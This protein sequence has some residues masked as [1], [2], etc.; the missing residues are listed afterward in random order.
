MGMKSKIKAFTLLEMLIVLGII[1]VIITIAATSY[2]S[3][4][5][6]SRDA[7]RKS[8]LKTVQNAFEQ[9]YSLCGFSYPGV[10]PGVE[11][12][13]Y[14]VYCTNPTTA[15]LPTPPVDPKTATPYIL[16]T[17]AGDN[18]TSSYKICTRLE[19]EGQATYCITNQQ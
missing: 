19:T 5:Q 18:S 3:S 10:T 7:R 14:P 6:K 9:Y 12:L 2:A 11:N 4:Q 15:F 17:G 16:P 8:D 1:A 13:G